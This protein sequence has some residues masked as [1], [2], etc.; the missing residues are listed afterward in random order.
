MLVNSG[1]E[2]GEILRTFLI[3]T[4]VSQL[5]VPVPVLLSA[6]L[7]L[8]HANIRRTLPMMLYVKE[9]RTL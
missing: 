4:R 1:N 6:G 2:D 8:E 9:V 7:L 5:S 3:S